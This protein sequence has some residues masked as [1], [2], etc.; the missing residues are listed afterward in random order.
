MTRANENDE[1]SSFPNI[2]A[3]FHPEI[4]IIGSY[5]EFKLAFDSKI[6]LATAKDKA[7]IEIAKIHNADISS[8]KIFKIE[9]VN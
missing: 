3:K 2:L 9:R 5:F 1:L 6:S 8:D 4:E 7:R